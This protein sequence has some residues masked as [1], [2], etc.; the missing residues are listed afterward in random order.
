[1]LAKYHGKLYNYVEIK[2]KKYLMTY[3]SRKIDDSFCAQRNYYLKDITMSMNDIE[4]IYA[5]HFW[6]TY[7]DT[8]E[9]K[10]DWL[11][12]EG[13]PLFQVPDIKKQEVG[14]VVMHDSKGD[15][16]IQHDKCAAS[17]IVKLDECE[18]LCIEKH[19]IFYQGC[20]ADEKKNTEVSSDEFINTIIA[21]R[22]ENN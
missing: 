15:S 7:K 5:L 14:L 20:S 19:S 17:K 16:W 1:M 18:K 11:V 6:V 9:D 22:R 10:V 8:I 2:E 4:E 12:D 13:Q 3:D 21:Y